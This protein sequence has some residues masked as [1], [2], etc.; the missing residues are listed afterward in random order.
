[1]DGRLAAEKAAPCMFEPD[2]E[3]Y[4]LEFHVDLWRGNS[5]GV[6]HPVQG[7]LGKEGAQYS[8][9]FDEAAAPPPANISMIFKVAGAIGSF[10]A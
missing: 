5:K 8:V 3:A 4:H 6:Y 1:M 2:G 9:R 10:A 7:E